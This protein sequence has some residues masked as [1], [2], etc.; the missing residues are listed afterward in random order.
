MVFDMA[1][2]LQQIE[3]LDNKVTAA[4]Q[5]SM[6][7]EVRRLAQRAAR[8]FLQNR[9]HPLDISAQIAQFREGIR[10]LSAHLPKLLRGPHL[11][12][13]QETREDLI[14]AGVPGD[15]ASSIAGMPSVFGGLDIVETSSA[16]DHS[17]LDV[18]EVYFDLA[19]R[20]DIAMIQ[21]RIVDLPRADRWQT[22]ARAALRD[23]LYAAHGGLTAALLAS[24]EESATP[25]QRYE[26]WLDRDRAAVERSRSVL[27]EIMS[28]DTFDLATL[29]VAMR[30]IS[31]ILR[32]TSI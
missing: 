6:R 12:R 31:A 5:T 16:S 28:S 29:S 30:T 22:M 17:V 15:L 9:R 10:D 4:V 7:M 20:M 19:D 21:Q 1:G 3:A 8:W 13:Y 25:E 24:S 26:A 11:T 27:T 23:E 32:A 14:I 18:A 2:Y